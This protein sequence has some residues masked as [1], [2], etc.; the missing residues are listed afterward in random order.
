[1]AA[2]VAIV[3]FLIARGILEIDVLAPAAKDRTFDSAMVWYAAVA[4]V[5]TLL[6]TGLAHLLILGAPE[7]MRFF[8]WIVGLATVV[9]ALLPFLGDAD[10]A[11]KVV[12]GVINLAIGISI[13][14]IVG[15]IARTS[16]TY[17]I[18]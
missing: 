12:T 10:L 16:Y 1:M 7:P 15:R 4:F 14:S 3:G 5:A 18:S 8:S 9:A 11:P 13:L 2:G 17:A 6:A